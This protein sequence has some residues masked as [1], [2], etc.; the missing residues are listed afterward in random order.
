M[1]RKLTNNKWEYLTKSLKFYNHQKAINKWRINKMTL[2]KDNMN[3][4]I[5]KNES[6]I[7][8]NNI[9]DILVNNLI[10]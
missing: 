2:N 9:C 6:F 10:I 8:E 1:N 4:Q 7:F 3:K 5:L